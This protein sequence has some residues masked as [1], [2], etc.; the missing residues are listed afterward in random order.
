MYLRNLCLVYEANGVLEKS[1]DRVL[2]LLIK[3]HC[4]RRVCVVCGKSVLQC[5]MSRRVFCCFAI[6]FV[7]CR[8]RQCESRRRGGEIF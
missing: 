6:G 2:S 1:C 4:Y 3:C 7:R 8:L 5:L